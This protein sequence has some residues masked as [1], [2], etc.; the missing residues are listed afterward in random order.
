M[1]KVRI[2]IAGA[3]FAA[4][5]HLDAYDRVHGVPIEVVGI[6]SLSAQSRDKLAEERKIK[7]FDFLDQLIKQADVIDVRPSIRT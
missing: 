5:F 1:E 2:G 6:T 3:G 4:R 7:A